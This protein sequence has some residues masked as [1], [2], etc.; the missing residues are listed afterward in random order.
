MAIRKHLP[1]IARRLD[2]IFFGLTGEPVPFILM[3]F[4]PGRAEFVHS[5]HDADQIFQ[6]AQ[7]A[8]DKRKAGKMILT[9][10]GR[11]PRAP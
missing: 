11:M 2:D 10:V 5:L 6:A 1:Q 3:A 9:G 4:P 7:Q 8:L